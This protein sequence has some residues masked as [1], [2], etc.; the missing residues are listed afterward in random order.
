MPLE[1]AVSHLFNCDN[2]TLARPYVL[3]QGSWL[4]SIMSLRNRPVVHDESKKHD[5]AAAP[6]R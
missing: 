3:P 5:N 1:I 6:M 2:L 4:N